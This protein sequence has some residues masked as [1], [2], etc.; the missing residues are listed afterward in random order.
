MYDI[1]TEHGSV[2]HHI[3]QTQQ[4]DK[5]LVKLITVIQRVSTEMTELLHNGIA[6]L[7]L[8]RVSEADS[9]LHKCTATTVGWQ[10]RGS[11]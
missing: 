4:G 7:Y 2:S 5:Y 10:R 6:T 11:V 9:S 8:S 1:L 3:Q